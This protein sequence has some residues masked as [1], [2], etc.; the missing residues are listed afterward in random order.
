MIKNIEIALPPFSEQ[1]RIVAYLDDLEAKVN[2]TKRMQAITAAELD[3]L[4][5]SVLDKAF[6]GRL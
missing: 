6:G 4:L 3:A 2:A 1:R 5:P